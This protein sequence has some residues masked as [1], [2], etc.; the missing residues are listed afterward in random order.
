MSNVE[1]HIYPGTPHGFFND[2]RPE[3]HDDAAGKLSWNRTVG[4]FREHLA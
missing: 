2:T 1:I 3:A 4:F